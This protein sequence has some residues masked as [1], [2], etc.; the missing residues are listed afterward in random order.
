MKNIET[1]F[2]DTLIK[3]K[4]LLFF[5]IIS[6]IGLIVRYCMR[7]YVSMD[8]ELYL[9]PW[10]DIIKSNGG[11]PSL[12]NQVGDYNIVYQTII[13]LMSYLPSEYPIFNPLYLYKIISV[14][15]DFLLAGAA[16]LLAA[17]IGTDNKALRFNVTYA[18]VLMLPTV[19]TNSAMWGQCDSIYTF[20]ILLSLYYLI[21]GKD[22]TAFILYGAAIS[23]KFQAIFLLPFF[24]FAYI[25]FRRF[26]LFLF[27]IPAAVLWLSGIP[28]YLYGRSLLTPFTIYAGQADEYHQLYANIVSFWHLFGERYDLMSTYAVFLTFT[29]FGIALYAVLS[30]HIRL[31][32]QENF[33]LAACWCLWTCVLFLPAMHERYTYPKDIVLLL[34]ATANRKYAKFALP[35]ICFSLITYGVFLTGNEGVG[36]WHSLISVSMWLYFTYTLACKKS[37]CT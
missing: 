3:Q 24:V 7:A 30:G 1:R 6:A 11:L 27:F 5:L 16:A 8:M 31:D 18:A 13:C 14:V 23:F 19:V 35:E 20:F 21:K 17:E 28:A 26:S 15:F 9:L 37:A 34:L 29:L 4:D 36:V 32:S 25:Y 2:V 10:Y 33:M 22:I 12:A